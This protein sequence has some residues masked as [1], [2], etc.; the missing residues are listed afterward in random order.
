M[1]KSSQLSDIPVLSRFLGYARNPEPPHSPL[2]FP[3]FS[4]LPHL[5][6]I[7]E[8]YLFGW[9][10]SFISILLI[11]ISMTGPHSAFSTVYHAPIIIASFGASAVLVFGA[12][13]VPLAQPRNLV[14]GHFVSALVGVCLTKLFG[15]DGNYKTWVMEVDSG[16]FHPVV[17]INGCLSMATSLTAMQVLRVVHP[18]CVYRQGEQT[19]N[20]DSLGV[21][22]AGATALLAAVN[23]TVFHLSWRYLPIVL[24][25]AL[26]MLGVGLISNNIGRRRYPKFWWKP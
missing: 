26:I 7:I 5:P 24:T 4:W 22:R 19:L 21:F 3:P 9:I 10:G 16:A 23:P 17:I 25:S 2:P 12:I 14:G 18:P 15:L 8:T 11:Q 1:S 6:I 13:D 20:A